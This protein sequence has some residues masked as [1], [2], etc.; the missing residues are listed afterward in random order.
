MVKIGH[1]Y[2]YIYIYIWAAIVRPLKTIFFHIVQ[3]VGLF[4]ILILDYQSLIWFDKRC[5]VDGTRGIHHGFIHSEFNYRTHCAHTTH[6]IRDYIMM[7]LF[8]NTIQGHTIK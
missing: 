4:N 8:Y 7:I 1:N 2:I 5:Q 6:A 3:S